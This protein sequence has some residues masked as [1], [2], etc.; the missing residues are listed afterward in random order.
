MEIHENVSFVNLLI[1]NHG[2]GFDLNTVKKKTGGSGLKNMHAFLE[3]LNGTF[4]IHSKIGKGTNI[5]IPNQ[6]L[7]LNA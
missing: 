5:E 1:S 7:A 2:E 4:K 6:L 3:L